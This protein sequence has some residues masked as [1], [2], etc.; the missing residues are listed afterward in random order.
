MTHDI[1]DQAFSELSNVYRD[2]IGPFV[3]RGQDYALLDFPEYNNVG[4][5]AIWMGQ[6]AFFDRHVGQ[7]ASYVSGCKADVRNLPD[8]VPEGPVFIQGGGNFGDVWPD[9]QNFRLH[10]WEVLKG[11]P[12]IQLPQSIHFRDTP[13]R[14]ATARA[15]ANHGQVTLIVRDKQSV[16]YVEKHF[17]CDV[18]LAPD[19]AVNMHHLDAAAPTTKLISF[20]RDDQEAAWPGAEA[21]LKD[22]GP[23]VDWPKVEVRRLTDRALRKGLS[24]INDGAEMR[25][26]ERMYRSEAQRRLWIGVRQMAPGRMIISDRLHVHLIASLIRRPHVVMDNM[27][28]KIARHISAWSDFGLARPISDI[29]TLR[30]IIATEIA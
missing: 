15:I 29:D 7:P 9:H 3:E 1:A 30:D 26:R 10:V 23:I 28:G 18:K 6:L 13:M 2:V 27:Y 11:R 20:L 5:S 21:L 17:D 22:Q 25:F 8:H 4:D 14:E 24:Y 12:V 16:E 19:G